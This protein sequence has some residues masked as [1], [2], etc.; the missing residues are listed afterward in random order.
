VTETGVPGESVT[1]GEM[2]IAT[3]GPRKETASVNGTATG[4][5]RNAGIDMKMSAE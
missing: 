3:T 5:R 2:K 4:T 1:R